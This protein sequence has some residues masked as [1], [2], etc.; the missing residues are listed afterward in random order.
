MQNKKQKNQVNRTYYINFNVCWRSSLLIIT[1]LQCQTGKPFTFYHMPLTILLNIMIT[2]R[3]NH[4]HL[5]H[6]ATLVASACSYNR[7]IRSLSISLSVISHFAIFYFSL[8]TSLFYQVI[9]IFI[10]STVV[11]RGRQSVPLLT[12]FRQFYK[13]HTYLQLL[14]LTIE[15][16]FLY[17]A[18]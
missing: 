16:V 12:C 17:F 8:I 15:T 4:S 13:V 3:Y 7:R 5:A 14:L 10:T 6:Q 2:L 9:G 18:H 11:E 1:A